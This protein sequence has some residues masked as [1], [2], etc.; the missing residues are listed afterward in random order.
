MLSSSYSGKGFEEEKILF[1]RNQKI[2]FVIRNFDDF[3]DVW[4][5]WGFVESLSFICPSCSTDWEIEFRDKSVSIQVKDMKRWRWWWRPSDMHC[6]VVKTEIQCDRRVRKEMEKKEDERSNGILNAIQS[7]EGKERHEKKETGRDTFIQTRRR[8]T[9][10]RFALFFLFQKNLL[11]MF[12]AGDFFLSCSHQFPSS[13]LLQSYKR[14]WIGSR[15]RQRITT[16]IE[17]TERWEERLKERWGIK[18]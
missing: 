6:M 18:R 14:K 7:I 8:W 11:P 5:K 13:F 17:W 9:T 16:S 10:E 3:Y 2:V 1:D 12:F 15:C 4:L